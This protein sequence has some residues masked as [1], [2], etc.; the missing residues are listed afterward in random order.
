[1]ASSEQPIY[2]CFNESYAYDQ[3]GGLLTISAFIYRYL[4][5]DAHRP[6]MLV[7]VSAFMAALGLPFLWKA[8]SQQWGVKVALASG[9]VYALYPE[10]I[11]LGGSAM[12]EPYLWAFSAFVLWGFVSLEWLEAYTA[13]ACGKHSGLL[14]PRNHG[15]A[16]TWDRGDV[17]CLACCGFGDSGHLCGVDVFRQ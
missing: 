7:L 10:S 6:L 3:Y 5:P 2:R 11:L 14:N 16:W 13:C 17:V 9:W 1:M 15:L 8:A 12:R 4:S